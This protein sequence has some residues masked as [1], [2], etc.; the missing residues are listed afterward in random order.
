VD[1]RPGAPPL[2]APVRRWD[3][4]SVDPWSD[5]HAHRRIYRLEE[6][7]NLLIRFHRTRTRTKVAFEICVA[8][9]LSVILYAAF[10]SVGLVV[11]VAAFFLRELM[12]SLLIE[13]C[14]AII[15]K[16]CKI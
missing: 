5:L 13:V 8:V 11:A 15:L 4:D 12:M 3:D 1:A 7:T 14:V 2:V 9:V 6:F 16:R 10:G